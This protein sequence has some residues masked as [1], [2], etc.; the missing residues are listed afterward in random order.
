MKKGN[1]AVFAIFKNQADAELAVDALKLEGFRNSDISTLMQS[2]ESTQEFAH[3]RSS[4]APE[5]AAA[6]AV[7]GAL[8]GA[9]LGWLAGIGSLA[10]PGVEAFLV[11]GPVIAALASAGLGGMIGGFSGA[12]IG[13]G[14]PEYEVKL[15]ES[16]MRVGGTLLSV[17]VDDDLWR[18]K[19]KN[20]LEQFDAKD[21]S[22]RNE[23]ASDTKM[24]R[25]PAWGETGTHA[26]THR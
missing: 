11:A 2:L 7:C 8:I 13:M 25:R 17:H 3:E 5:G 18:R 10:I 1:K 12:F 19:A 20:I 15:Y 14:I 24:T 4:K 9:V 21:I 26:A 22:S 23:L 6:G 16:W